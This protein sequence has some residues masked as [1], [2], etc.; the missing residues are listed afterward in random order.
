MPISNHQTY[1][2]NFLT[3]CFF[4]PFLLCIYVPAIFLFDVTY[5][6]KLPIS[7]RTKN[8]LIWW[9]MIHNNFTSEC[10]VLW[11][12][13]VFHK[14]FSE[15]CTIYLHA[16]EQWTP[17]QYALSIIFYVTYTSICDSGL[18]SEIDSF[19]IKIP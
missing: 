9:F 5:C 4:T 17:Q 14:H 19:I 6:M 7:G 2:I 1:F 13:H 15:S 16:R 18:L 3:N 11:D 10:V 8:S 12:A